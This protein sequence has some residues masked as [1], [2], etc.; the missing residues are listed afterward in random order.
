MQTMTG[1]TE[2]KHSALLEVL[3]MET[4]E[5]AAVHGL[6]HTLR[7]LG[8]VRFALLRSRRACCNACWARMKT[9]ATATRWRSAAKWCAT[10]VRRAARSCMRRALRCSPARRKPMPVP[11]GKN[12]M[13][14][15]L[16]TDLALRFVTLLQPPQARGV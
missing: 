13:N 5:R 12:K 1:K 9:F 6:V 15:S 3:A 4:G 14:L 8:D 10:S 16:D 2:G 11:I 7:D